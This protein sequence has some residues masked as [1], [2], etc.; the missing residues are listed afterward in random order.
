MF[1]AI[2]D[3][4]FAKGRFVLMGGVVALITLL[5]VMLSGLTAG[6]ADQSTSA[7]SKL[8]TAEGDGQTSRA[9]DSIVFGAPAGAEAKASFTESEVSS[10]QLAH[11]RSAP[12]VSSVEALGI[13]QARLQT[14][15]TGNGAGTGNVALFGVSPT[16]GLAPVGFGSDTVVI[17]QGLAKQLALAVGDKVLIAGKELSVAAIVPD[18][19]Y[20]HTSVVWLP[21]A[22]WREIAHLDA[23][24]VGT[25]AAVSYRP[26]TSVDETAMNSQAGTVSTSRT[27]S[28]QAL[29]SYRSENGS[30]LLMQAFL[31]GISALVII[32]F[33]TVWTIQRTRDIA[34]LKAIGASSGYLLRDAIAQAAVVLL[35][36]AGIGTGVGALGGLLAAQAAP[37]SLNAGSTLLPML[38]VILLGLLGAGFAVGQ[39]TRIDPLIALGGN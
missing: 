17:G 4:R 39:V 7:L 26:D 33:L 36:G 12:G 27:G 23:G 3:I 29:S 20:S 21:L 1:L 16:G 9:V 35:V 31:Y 24:K 25:V 11:W 8:G 30:L 13:S 37:F 10:A 6:L 15:Q 14:A 34:V 22:S 5:L 32:A 18:Q 19:W 2:R 38:G 28:F